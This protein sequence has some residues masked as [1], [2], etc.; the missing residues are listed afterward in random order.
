MSNNDS[1]WAIPS[2]F[3]YFKIL[4]KIGFVDMSSVDL[5]VEILSKTVF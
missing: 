5:N 1:E 2:D 4:F 3:E